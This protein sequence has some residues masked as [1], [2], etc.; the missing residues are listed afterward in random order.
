MHAAPQVLYPLGGARVWWTLVGLLV[1]STS[2][3]IAAVAL[4]QPGWLAM[5]MG[6]LML[7]G[8][9]W[10]TRGAP[11]VAGAQLLWDGECWHLLGPRP[12]SG[13]LQLALDL[14]MALLLRWVS[15]ISGSDSGPMWLW[16]EQDTDPVI[17]KD[18]RRAVYW[19]AR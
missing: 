6:A 1:L 5:T 19:N 15:P 4:S 14:Q 8:C 3:L 16:I 9:W 13:Q 17:W 10:V 18:V 2:A 11:S 12:M 7:P